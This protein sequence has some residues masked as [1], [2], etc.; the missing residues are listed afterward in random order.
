MKR[1]QMAETAITPWRSDL[2]SFLKSF[3]SDNSTAA[4]EAIVLDT[5][6]DFPTYQCLS[7]LLPLA[8]QIGIASINIKNLMILPAYHRYGSTKRKFATNMLLTFC[9]T[10]LLS[11]TATILVI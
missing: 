4:F 5:K 3:G 11:H 9:F 10:K 2:H 1:C 8:Q 7:A 6:R